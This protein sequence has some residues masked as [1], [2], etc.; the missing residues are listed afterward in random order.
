[1]NKIKRN[2][3]TG[4]VAILPLVITFYVFNWLLKIVLKLIH[5]TIV[6]K[7]IQRIIFLIYGE[8]GNEFEFKVLVY[9]ISILIMLIFI[10]ILGY[11]TKM[12]FFS[13]IMTKISHLIEKLPVIKTV[14]TTV[15]QILD[16]VYKNDGEAAYQKVVVIEYP[17]KG[18]YAIGFLM[19][20]RN[21]ILE[22]TLAKEEI[23]NVFVP[24]SPNPTSGMLLCVPKNEVYQVDISVEMAFKLIISGGYITEDTLKEKKLTE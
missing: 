13:K 23:A 9:F 19:A 5:D 8:Y 21:R 2:F 10:T 14:Y 1:M 4:L 24:T 17:R 6:T 3:L 11:T 7:T 18:I 12:V 15:R 22:E 20:D 16:M